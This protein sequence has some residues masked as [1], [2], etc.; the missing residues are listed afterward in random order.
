MVVHSPNIQHLT[1][2][3]TYHWYS[4]NPRMAATTSMIR[5]DMFSNANKANPGVPIN[6]SLPLLG[7]AAAIKLALPSAA[8]TALPAS[9]G[10][11]HPLRGLRPLKEMGIV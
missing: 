10:S 1:L 9:H 2:S 3:C 7:A 11:F 6:Q 8:S 4:A 5:L